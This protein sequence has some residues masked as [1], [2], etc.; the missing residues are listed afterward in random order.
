MICLLLTSVGAA[1][2]LFLFDAGQMVS[3]KTRVLTAAD[4]AAYSAASWRARVLNYN[5]YSNR[6]IVAQ[7]VAVAQAITLESWANYFEAF[8]ESIETLSQIY[9]PVYTYAKAAAEAA[10]YSR[11]ATQY[12]AA[13][14]IR[15]RDGPSIGYKSMLTYS[16]HIM[17]YS[18]SDFGLT[19]IAQ[20]VA[21]TADNRIKAYVLPIGT[22]HKDFIKHYSSDTDRQR[23][24]RIVERSLDRF[25][26]GTR[27][28]N[29]SLG[30]PATC[31]M[32]GDP[33]HEA[34]WH[35]RK[36]GGTKLAPGLDRWEAA[37]TGS[38]QVPVFSRRKGRCFQLEIY[39]MGWGAAEL[40]V[41]SQE[42]DILDNPGAVATNRNALSN[43]VDEMSDSDRPNHQGTGI[44]RAFD[45]N[46][47]KL[48]NKRFPVSRVVVLTKLKTGRLRLAGAVLPDGERLTPE[49]TLPK[50][51]VRAVG[52]AEVYFRRP[53]SAPARR[54]YASLYNPFWQVRLATAS[55]AEK[56]VA[57]HAR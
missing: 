7:E 30:V 32:P 14:E 42:D 21:G 41:G 11:L 40:P 18:A 6:A 2:T 16:Q 57:A 52:V 43:A 9:P 45:L 37:D 20:E 38:V 1:A 28:A 35:Y 5:A 29:L 49:I 26:A 50:D 47:T 31:V 34:T 25:T 33:P 15:L 23:M 53:P 19:A 51:E 54:E 27:D 12:A 56:G 13:L 8:T 44:A 48:P 24:R 22:K 4:T 46:Y 10:H 36:R 39:P 55:A 17:H 3:A